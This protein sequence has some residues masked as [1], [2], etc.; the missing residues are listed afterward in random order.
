MVEPTPFDPEAVTAGVLAAQEAAQWALIQEG[1]LKPFPKERHKW[2]I[3]QSGVK[4][5]GPWAKILVYVDARMVQGRLDEAVGS[6]NWQTQY[7]Q[8]PMGGNGM[9]CH[10]SLRAGAEY[11][12]VTKTDGAD[13]TDIEGAKGGLSDAFKRAAVQWGVGRYLYDAPETW[14]NF[15]GNGQNSCKID[16]K[17]YKWDPPGR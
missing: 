1:L 7:S 4:S 5:G 6:G 8:H 9:L 12:W 13:P 17:W 11:E 16:G 15:H 3:A 10:L 2:R 14:A